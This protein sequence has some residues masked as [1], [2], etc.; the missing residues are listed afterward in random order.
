[1]GVALDPKNAFG[2]DAPIP[3]QLKIYVIRMEDGGKLMYGLLFPWR[4][5]VSLGN[6]Q[7][8]LSST[9]QTLTSTSS[10]VLLLH[11]VVAKGPRVLP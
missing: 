3:K 1:M 11:N 9:M 2:S 10:E 5:W 4:L 7:V 6:S 8:D